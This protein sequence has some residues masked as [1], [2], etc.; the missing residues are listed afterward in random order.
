VK[1]F[2]NLFAIDL[3]TFQQLEMPVPKIEC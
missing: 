3:V 1:H 2:E